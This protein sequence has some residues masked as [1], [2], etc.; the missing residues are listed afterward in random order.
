M[1]FVVGKTLRVSDVTHNV[2]HGFLPDELVEVLE[3]SKGY[4]LDK[5][6]R[7]SSLEREHTSVLLAD[8][9]EEV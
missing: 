2:I 1:K 9:V 6:A 4:G 5:V 3:I 7:C 8:E